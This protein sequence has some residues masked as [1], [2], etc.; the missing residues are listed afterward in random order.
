MNR[1]RNNRYDTPSFASQ[2]PTSASAFDPF[3]DP[4]STSPTGTGPQCASYSPKVFYAIKGG[5]RKIVTNFLDACS[6]LENDYQ[7]DPTVLVTD[8]VVEALLFI[9]Q[10]SRFA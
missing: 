4:V 2:S 7:N 6:E 5:K 1:T 3:K 9:K 8:S 10:G